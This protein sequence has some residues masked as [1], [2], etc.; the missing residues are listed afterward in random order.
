MITRT[1][2]VWAL[3]IAGL[4]VAAPAQAIPVFSTDIMGDLQ[5]MY[6]LAQRAETVMSTANNYAENVM[7]T[8]MMVKNL[9][10]APL[11]TLSQM[12]GPSGQ[13]YMAYTN[14]GYQAGQLAN[15]VNGQAMAYQSAYS[16][17]SLSQLSPTAFIQAEESAAYGSHA[18]SQNELQVA[19]AAAQQTDSQI[20]AVQKA[21]QAIPANS[22]EQRQL[23]LLNTQMAAQQKADQTEVT[24]L[25]AVVA[26]D[27]V[28]NQQRSISQAAGD[29]SAR[30]A[31]SMFS[32]QRQALNYSF[33]APAPSPQ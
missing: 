9:K 18:A 23:Q 1:G 24:Q 27:A 5:R 7:Q 11:Q 29:S 33:R 30:A 21:E 8:Y 31:A 32:G 28:R 13:A 16:S 4:V 26:A 17:F 6:A 2:S 22:G 19:K 10:S 15:D 25:N 12:S 3:M 20:Q 14:L